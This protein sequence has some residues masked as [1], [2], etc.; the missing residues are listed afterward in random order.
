MLTEE[1]FNKLV[2]DCGLNTLTHNPSYTDYCDSMSKYNSYFVKALKEINNKNL[3][4]LFLESGPNP[5]S[6]Y[7][8]E[9]RNQQINYATDKF[10]W[11]TCVG[12][13]IDPKKKKKEWCLKQLYSRGEYPVLIIDLFPFHGI[14]L[15]EPKGNP[16]RRGIYEKFKADNNLLT[17]AIKD[18]IDYL[19]K[20]S[21]KKVFLFGV[22]GSF[23]NSFGGPGIGSICL[24]NRVKK[25][26]SICLTNRAKKSGP[27]GDY[28]NMTNIVNVGGQT[29]SS[30]AIKTWLKAEGVK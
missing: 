30:Y 6:N 18:P 7:I 5:L 29:I 17:L 21:G 8:F 15:S 20:V 12:F 22:P 23:W 1:E 4:V 10:L 16:I 19:N 13:G 24:T 9:N 26:G 28:S 27:L 14:N 2:D 11:N 3:I 25:I